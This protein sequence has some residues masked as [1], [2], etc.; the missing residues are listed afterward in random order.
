[1]KDR[2]ADTEKPLQKCCILPPGWYFVEDVAILFEGEETDPDLIKNGI[3]KIKSNVSERTAAAV[4]EDMLLVAIAKKEDIK[5]ARE[6]IL[7][8]LREIN[9]RGE[10]AFIKE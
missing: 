10:L 4:T 2:D 6:K 3:E 1:M 5:E 9:E 7:R 8:V